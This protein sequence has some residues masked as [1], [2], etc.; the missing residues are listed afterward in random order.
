MDRRRVWAVALCGVCLVA[1]ADRAFP[2][3]PRAQQAARPDAAPPDPTADVVYVCPMDLDVRSH[4]AGACKRC[5]MALVGEVPSPVEFHLGVRVMPPSPK[6][7][8]AAVVQFVVHDPWKDRPVSAFSA[9]HERLF[10]A[11]F[12]SEDLEFFE[13]GHPAL[14][15]D[16]VFQYP[17]RFRKPGM[18]RILCDF[19]PVGGTP[20][21]TTATVFAAGGGSNPPVKLER[22]Y[23]QKAGTN[24]QVGLETIPEHPSPGNRTQMRFTVDNADGLQQYLGAWGHLL[25][26]S[27]DLVD[28]IHEH[29]SRTDEGAQIEFDVVFPRPRTY[30]VWAQFQR[31][32]AVNTVRFDVP[33]QAP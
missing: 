33:V 30:R 23:S 7:E 29:P 4:T 26:V 12:V 18:H 8:T 31:R 16:G 6:P 17:I 1:R 28:M 22:D 32:N 24:M 27:D 19:F 15:A 9:V 13:H 20:Q 21:L 5:G 3:D 10:H 11:F 2:I 25:A 14:V